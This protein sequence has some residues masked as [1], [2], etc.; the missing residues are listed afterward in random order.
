VTVPLLVPGA[1]TCPLIAGACRETGAN[2]I[3]R[4]RRCL[5]GGWPLLR[6][7][8]RALLGRGQSWPQAV[9]S[10]QIDLTAVAA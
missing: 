3:L 8:R 9:L 5:P 4:S 7:A 1:T 10:Q 2:L 6:G